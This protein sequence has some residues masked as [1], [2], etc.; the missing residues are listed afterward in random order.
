[1]SQR[2][3]PFLKVY[4]ETMIS[5]KMWVYQECSQFAPKITCAIGIIIALVKFCV[6]AH[7]TG[8]FNNMESYK[9]IA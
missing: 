2:R 4:L 6:I 1:M 8:E 7:I 9:M 3:M 5:R